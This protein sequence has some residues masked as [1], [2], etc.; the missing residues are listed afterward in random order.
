[1]PGPKG[2]MGMIGPQGPT[3][4]PGPPGESKIVYGEQGVVL[5]GDKVRVCQ[6][7]YYTTWMYYMIT[8][9]T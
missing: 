6:L 9:F 8:E 3:G 4:L 5:K 1:M 7:T 2:D